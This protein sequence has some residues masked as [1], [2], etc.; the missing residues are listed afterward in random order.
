M[1]KTTLLLFAAAL[2]LSGAGCTAQASVGT[3]PAP[4]VVVAP[5]GTLTVRWAIAGAVD[6]GA[7]AF[8]RADLFELVIFNPD[9]SVHAQLTAPCENFAVSHDLAEDTY[10]ADATLIDVNDNPVT[11]TEPLDNLDII[12]GQELVV[13]I[14]FPT[15]SVL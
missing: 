10:N 1:T 3:E 9:G 15:R 12:G 4:R 2:G 14:D 6:P 13:D 5:V 7:C 11:V 8:Y